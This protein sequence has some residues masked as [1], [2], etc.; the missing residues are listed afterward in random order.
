VAYETE[1]GTAGADAGVHDD[2]DDRARLGAWSIALAIVVFAAAVALPLFREV[3]TRP[4]QTMW[5]EDGTIYY[6]QGLLDGPSSLLRTYSGYVQFVPRALMQLVLL[7]PTAWAAAV[8]AVLG[9]FATAVIAA[10]VY[11]STKGWIA[12]VPFRLAVPLMMTLAPAMQWENTGNLTNL[13]WALVAAVPWALVSRRTKPLDLALRVLVV[14]LA[15]LSQPLCAVWVPVAVLVWWRRRSRESLVVGSALVVGLGVQALLMLTGGD[16]EP[17]SVMSLKD[18]GR[19]ITTEFLGSFVAGDSHRE[20]WVDL[21]RTFSILAALITLAVFVVVGVGA[22]PRARRLCGVLLYGAA[23]TSVVPLLTNRTPIPLVEGELPGH[24]GRY[25]VL[26]V[27]MLVGALAVLLDYPDAARR[28][29]VATVGR[30]IFGIQLVVL[31]VLG[32]RILSPRGVGAQW[33]PQLNA[34]EE[35]CRDPATSPDMVVSIATAPPGWGVTVPCSK[36]PVP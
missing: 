14:V 17:S 7:V 27:V 21:G 36:L 29:R 2:E 22:S 12:T 32:F 6:Q 25:I 26:P 34:A 11:R 4:W 33:T 8:A 20:L 13:I 10:F 31:V 18:M 30:W 9:S 15:A 1:V 24:A 19:L 3:G 35:I 5:A 16:R 23:V 28:R